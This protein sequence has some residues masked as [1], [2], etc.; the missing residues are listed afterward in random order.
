[1][2]EKNDDTERLLGLVNEIAMVALGL[3]ED[4][5]EHYLLNQREGHLENAISLGTPPEK[6]KE[7]AAQM[8]EWTRAA[9]GI[10]ERSG[11]GAGGSA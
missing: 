1:M 3:P 10:I 2:V 8:D 9:I 4:Q 11:G 6:A 7:L 5:R